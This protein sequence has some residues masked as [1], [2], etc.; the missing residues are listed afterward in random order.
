MFSD[1][2]DADALAEDMHID[3]DVYMSRRA[4][5]FA[6]IARDTGRDVPKPDSDGRLFVTYFMA[7]DM[8]KRARTTD[9]F[10]AGH[11]AQLEEDT[12]DAEDN[13]VSQ[14]ALVAEDAADATLTGDATVTGDTTLAGGAAVAEGDVATV[15]A[16]QEIETNGAGVVQIE[17]MATDSPNFFSIAPLLSNGVQDRCEGP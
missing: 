1:P 11:G 8:M 5:F 3:R 9:W 12:A 14:G 2:I 6:D 15:D 4:E 7:C 17:L 10:R 16:A 13:V